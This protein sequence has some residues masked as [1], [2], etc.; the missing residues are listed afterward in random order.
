[1]TI[2][3]HNIVHSWSILPFQRREYG[4]HDDRTSPA[5]G[6]DSPA[7]AR[8]E[9]QRHLPRL[10]SQPALVQQMVGRVSAPSAERLGRPYV[11]PAYLATPSAC[12]HPPRGGGGPANPRSGCAARHTLRLD[13]A[14]PPPGG[15]CAPWRE[16]AS[17]SGDDSA[18]SGGPTVDSSALGGQ[19]HGLLPPAPGV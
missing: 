18:H 14:S 12:S 10:E 16:A 1:M 3:N 7:P 19:S 15:V 17:Q 9:A 4:H 2:C 8:R 5:P 13:R 6:S 11:R